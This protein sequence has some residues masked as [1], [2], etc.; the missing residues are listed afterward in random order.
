MNKELSPGTTLSH[1]RVAEKIGAGGMG[2]VYLAEDTRLRRKVAVKVLPESVA[3]DEVRLRRFEREAVAASSLNHPNILTVYE[4]GVEGETHFLAAEYVE[5]E[6]LRARLQRAPFAIDEALDVAAQTARALAAA[7]E[8]KIIHRDIK[9][10]NIMVRRDGY[11]KVLDFGLAKL[12]EPEPSSAGSECPTMPFL[13]TEAGVVIGT[14]PYMSPEQAR[15]VPLDARTDVWSLG[16]VVYEM[17]TGHRPFDGETHTDVIVSVL[18]R[19][20]PPVSSFGRDIPAELEW[21][22]SKALTKDVAGR[23]QTA[24]ELRVDLEKIRRRLELGESLS[25]SASVPPEGPGEKTRVLTAAAQ[26]LPT[27]DDADER[28]AGPPGYSRRIQARRAPYAILAAALLALACAAVY[29]GFGASGDGRRIDSIA[30][31]PFDNL[32]GNPDMTFV[33]DGLS[34]ALIDRLSELPQL[35][36]ISRHSSFAFRG[37]GNNLREVATKLG[38]RAVV[39]GKVSQVGDDLVVRLDVVDAVEDRHLAGAQFRR[40]PGDLL[41]I[42]S[43]IAQK[44]TEQ[45]RVRLTDAQSKRLAENGT[46][47]SEAYRFYLSGLVELNGPEDVRGRALE[48]FERAVALD[49]GFAAAHAEIGFVY[50]SRANGS[51]DPQ[52]LVPKAKAATERALAIDPDLAKAHVVKAMLSEYDFDWEGAEREYRRALELSPNL[53]FARNY[54]AFFLSVLG[55]HDD[56]LAELEQQRTLDPINQRLALIHKGLILTQA[57]RFDEALRAYQEAQAVEPGREVPHFSLGYAF[58]GQGRLEEAAAHYRKSVGLLGGEEKYSQPLVYLAATYAAMP[59]KRGEARAILKRIEAMRDYSSPALL[60][61]A[62]SA[63]GENDR[64]MELLERAYAEH[65]PL[66]RFIGTGY[67]YD[68]LRADPRF[69]ALTRRAGLGQ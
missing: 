19:E 49:P 45:L 51:S 24:T 36:V 62:Y 10:E 57:R 47:N 17:L 38:V 68:G 39:T 27:A 7:H 32:S 8:A 34:E 3:H 63:L 11:V 56:A 37:V 31:L 46:E 67:E 2:Q 5:G 28:A 21:V 4:F 41:S 58:A 9:P 26:A 54:Y 33:S 64:A 66:L 60:A 65:D 6:T 48:Y 29:F 20:P 15:G 40:K 55:R 42:Q 22:V 69:V 25:R 13:R 23:Y 12:S 50:W 16:V 14:A 35:R 61:A 1:Y 53:G 44:A 59:E 18:S 52:A 43:E 30:V